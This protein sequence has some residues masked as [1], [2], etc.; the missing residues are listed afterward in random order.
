MFDA[1]RYCS[2]KIILIKRCEI[3]I[4]IIATMNNIKILKYVYFFNFF[5]FL[6]PRK[7]SGKD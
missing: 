4:P 7:I 1:M 6:I 2:P 3:N 5:L